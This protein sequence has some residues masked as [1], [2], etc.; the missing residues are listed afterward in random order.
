MQLNGYATDIRYPYFEALTVQDGLIAIQ[1]AQ[2]VMSFY[3]EKLNK[4]NLHEI[5][6]D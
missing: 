5:V 2:K 4:L 1:H 6:I 3:N